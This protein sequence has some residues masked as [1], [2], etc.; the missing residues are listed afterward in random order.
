MFPTFP[1]K[2]DVTP[3][4]SERINRRLLSLIWKVRAS[5]QLPDTLYHYT[6]PAGFKGIIELAFFAQRTFLTP[7]TALNYFM[8]WM[9]RD[10]VCAIDNK[11]RVPNKKRTC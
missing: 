8:P 1:E 4:E 7:T 10:H 9:L 6:T 3:D 5:K 11:S 2:P